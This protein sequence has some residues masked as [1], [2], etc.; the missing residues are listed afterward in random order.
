MSLSFI[1]PLAYHCLQIF[2]KKTRGA[3]NFLEI[4]IL[5]EIL[6]SNYYLQTQILLKFRRFRI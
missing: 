4:G 3:E 1:Y 6:L 5:A 2:G